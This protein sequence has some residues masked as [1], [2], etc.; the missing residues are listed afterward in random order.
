MPIKKAHLSGFKKI[1]SGKSKIESEY[2]KD[3]MLNLRLNLNY[4]D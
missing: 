4:V 3:I 1:E 2:I